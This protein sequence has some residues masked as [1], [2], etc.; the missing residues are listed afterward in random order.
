MGKQPH[1]FMFAS[2]YFHHAAFW[3]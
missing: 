1:I 3:I 2:S